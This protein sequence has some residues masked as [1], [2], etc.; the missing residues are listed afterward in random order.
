MAGP[1]L[2]AV[3]LQPRLSPGLSKKSSLQQSFVERSTAVA[4]NVGKKV[5]RIQKNSLTGDG[6]RS[7][8]LNM[9]KN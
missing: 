8:K 5:E 1:D 9:I 7:Y 4:G 2:D 3:E 6:R